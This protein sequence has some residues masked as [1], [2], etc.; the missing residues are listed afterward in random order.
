MNGFSEQGG[1]TLEAVGDPDRFVR[2]GTDDDRPRS[3]RTGAIQALF[4]RR[5]PDPVQGSA[6]TGGAGD[7]EGART[8]PAPGVWDGRGNW[9]DPL[10]TPDPVAFF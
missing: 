9:L 7:I 1:K 3:R 4:G 2:R 6:I 8:T 5:S 10:L